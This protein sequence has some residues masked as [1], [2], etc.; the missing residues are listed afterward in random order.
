M[1][2]TTSPV[3]TTTTTTTPNLDLSYIAIN[4]TCPGSTTVFFSKF[5][6]GGWDSGAGQVASQCAGTGISTANGADATGLFSA[7]LATGAV[8]S[9]G[10]CTLLLAVGKKGQTCEIL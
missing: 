3:T 9:L 2:S 4:Y 1:A 6:S 5:D 8:S 7:N 10:A